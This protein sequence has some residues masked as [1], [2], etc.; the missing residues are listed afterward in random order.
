MGEGKITDLHSDDNSSIG[1]RI[2]RMTPTSAWD[3][4]RHPD[5]DRDLAFE[6]EA[7]PA[8]PLG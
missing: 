6:P 3:A 2:R 5:E 7:H 1:V 8:Q 4:R